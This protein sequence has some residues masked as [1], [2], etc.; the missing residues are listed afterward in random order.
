ME[1]I[2][3]TAHGRFFMRPYQDDDEE[4]VIQLWETAFNSKM[5]RRIWRWKF[6]DNPFGRQMMLCIN[7]AGEPIAMYSGIPFPA[8]LKGEAIRMTQLI[9]NMSH[10]EYRQAVSGRKGLFVKCSEHFFDVYGGK[11][12]SVYHYGFPGIKHFKLGKLLLQYGMVSDG[13]A[14]LEA[15]PKKQGFSSLFSFARIEQVSEIDDRFDELWKSNKA[16]YPFSIN[17]DST[18]LKWRFSRNP[19]NTYEIYTI[20]GKGKISAYA[21]VLI[22]ENESIIVDVFSGR[23]TKPLLKLL[24]HVSHKMWFASVKKIKVWLPK[25]HFITQAF[26][27]TGFSYMDEPLGIVPT[28]RSLDESLDFDFTA[29]NIFYTMADGDLF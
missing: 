27:N 12:A 3:E 2:I 7:E 1:K 13:G 26:I 5:D 16:H 24:S 18:F 9:D 19:I 17:R 29:K 8:N 22:K 11:H 20:S 6:H 10:P 25:N 14:Y 21:V 23:N 28:G 15:L 4:K